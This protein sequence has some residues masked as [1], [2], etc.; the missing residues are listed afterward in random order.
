MSFSQVMKYCVFLC[1]HLEHG[2]VPE[3]R[4]TLVILPLQQDAFIA[5]LF[6][7][8]LHTRSVVLVV[9]FLATRVTRLGQ[10]SQLAVK[11]FVFTN[12]RAY[13]CHCDEKCDVFL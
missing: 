6:H 8:Q 12:H 11:I 7:R 13:F 9:H 1:Y 5:E 10:I 2:S 3:C 4:E